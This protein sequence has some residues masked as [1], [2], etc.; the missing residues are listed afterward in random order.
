MRRYHS[1]PSIPFHIARVHGVQKPARS[2]V[3]AMEAAPG[4]VGRV[5]GSEAPV[6]LKNEPLIFLW[7]LW[8]AG[9]S[10]GV[11]LALELNGMS[12]SGAF[13]QAFGFLIAAVA[14]I[15]KSGDES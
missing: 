6:R 8:L 10:V 9:V 7:S 3:R 11:G 1:S 13:A 2:S 15:L 12:Q 5:E 4:R 14:I